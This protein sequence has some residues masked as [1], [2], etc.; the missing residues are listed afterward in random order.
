MTEAV[1]E[2]L[3]SDL[4]KRCVVLL[5]DID[6]AGLTEAR[7]LLG[8]DDGDDDDKKSKKPKIPHSG[9]G[10]SRISLSALLNVIDGVA[11]SEGRILIMTTN[12]MENLDKA[13]IRPGRVDMTVKFDLASTQIISTIFRSIYSSSEDDQPTSTNLHSLVRP[14]KAWPFEKADVLTVAQDKKKQK[15]IEAKRVA[16]ESKI[17]ALGTRFAEVV[18]TMTF[19]PAEIQ[20][21]LLHNKD[22]PEEAVESAAAW[23]KATTLENSKKKKKTEEKKVEEV[24]RNWKSVF[25]GSFKKPFL[26]L[27]RGSDSA[28]EKKEKS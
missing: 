27:K 9:A 14:V 6:S 8:E 18:P 17:K 7:D 1:L 10:Q 19:S 11:A 16:R 3:F 24:K 15:A 12:H 26:K 22:D 23:V 20:G 28:K 4:P 2:S 5:E 25:I 21:H 13:L